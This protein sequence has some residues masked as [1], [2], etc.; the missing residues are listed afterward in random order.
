MN[1][2]NILIEALNLATTK[3][4]FNLQETEKILSAVIKLQNELKPKEVEEK[5]E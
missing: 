4:A 3:G 1:E 2:L 5:N